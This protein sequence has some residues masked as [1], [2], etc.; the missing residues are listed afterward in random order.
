MARHSR[1]LSA[2]VI[3][4]AAVA[5]PS[6][7]GAQVSRIGHG[8]NIGL[9]AV[10]GWPNVGIGLNAF[11]SDLNSIQVALTWSYR[12]AHGYFG[13][14]GDFLFWMQRIATSTA[15]DVRWYL[16]PGVN[17]ARVNGL[18]ARSDGRIIEDGAFFLEAEMPVG[19]A[20][21]FKIPLDVAL[22]GIPKLFLFDSGNG[23]ALRLDFAAAVNLRYYF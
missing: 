12:N 16:G 20:L 21:Q 2:L 15:L 18:Y 13:L 1:I 8:R 14:R 5:L 9:G 22:E 6:A 23:A 17:L 19:I 10:L 3:A 7:A 11:L 4:A